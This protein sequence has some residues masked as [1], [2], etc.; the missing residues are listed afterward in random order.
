MAEG[1]I[2]KPTPVVGDLPGPVGHAVVV[3]FLLWFAAHSGAQEIEVD[4]IHL[5]CSDGHLE[6]VILAPRHRHTFLTKDGHPLVHLTEVTM[7]RR[8]MWRVVRANAGI[9]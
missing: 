7:L 5:L 9:G 8:I 6:N 3:D 4:I 2:K 1:S